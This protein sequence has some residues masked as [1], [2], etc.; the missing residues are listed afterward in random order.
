M[1]VGGIGRHPLID[2][3]FGLP[4]TLYHPFV[5]YCLAT[6]PSERLCG[7]LAA[8]AAACLGYRLTRRPSSIWANAH[9]HIFHSE[10]T[11][12]ILSSSASLV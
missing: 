9:M 8:G 12:T 4:N 10:R 7:P 3:Y 6:K 2:T 5:L 1:R 11:S